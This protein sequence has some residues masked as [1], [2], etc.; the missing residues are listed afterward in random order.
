MRL[1]DR[2]GGVALAALLAIA[3]LSFESHAQQ[4]RENLFR[5]W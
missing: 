1:F 4:T 2:R 3:A 5:I